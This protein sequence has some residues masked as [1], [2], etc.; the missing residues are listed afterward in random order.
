MTE[1]YSNS[2]QKSSKS[3]SNIVKSVSTQEDRQ[4]LHENELVTTPF[5]NQET[6]ENSNENNSL[7]AHRQSDESSIRNRVFLPDHLFEPVPTQQS[8]LSQLDS[9]QAFI[10]LGL[11]TFIAFLLS[12]Y[13]CKL[14]LIQFVGF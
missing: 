12:K 7:I 9:L 2:S 14:L 6:L 4:Q 1:I 10:C 8:T 13:F 3:I 11:F 5:A